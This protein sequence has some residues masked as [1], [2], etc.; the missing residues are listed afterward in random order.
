MA[1]KQRGEVRDNSF[2]MIVEKSPLEK[3][4]DMTGRCV[5]LR[6]SIWKIKTHINELAFFIISSKT[7][8][9]ISLFVIVLNSVQLATQDPTQTETPPLLDTLDTIFL[10]FYTSEMVIKIMGLGFI[11]SKNAYLRDP[12]NVLDFVIVCTGLLQVAFSGGSLNLTGMRSFRVLRPLKTIS[13]IEGLRIIVSALLKSA[14]LLME[15]FIVLFFFYLLF[16]IA[17][18]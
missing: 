16:S 8:D 9:G 15:T 13:G 3:I 1:A 11:L 2:F 12:W 14:K 17:G 7:F 10:I 4:D 6:Q 5:K 18:L